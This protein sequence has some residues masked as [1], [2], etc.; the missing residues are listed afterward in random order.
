M[1]L[2]V[3]WGTWK[4]ATPPPFRRADRHPCGVAH[5]ALLESGYDPK[6]VRCYG[7][8]ALPA[9]F[10]LTPGRRKVKQLTGDVMVPVLETGDGEVIA[11]SQ[12]IAAW[13]RGHPKPA[14]SPAK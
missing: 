12:E 2:Y 13:A 5:E 7:W 10:N 1:K 14:T 9:V 6:V 11:G 8:E 4:G 3:C